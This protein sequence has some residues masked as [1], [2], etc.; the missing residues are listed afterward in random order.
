MPPFRRNILSPSSGLKHL[1][2]SLHGAKTQNSIIITTMKMFLKNCNEV[3]IRFET[4]GRSGV[5]ILTPFSQIHLFKRICE[6]FHKLQKSHNIKICV[7]KTP[8]PQIL[9]KLTHLCYNYFQNIGLLIIYKTTLRIVF[10]NFNKLENE[11]MA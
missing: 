3:C 6:G 7:V 10:C 9:V 4:I 8:T 2:T 5:R 1:P 11:Y